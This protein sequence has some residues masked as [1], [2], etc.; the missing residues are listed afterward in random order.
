MVRSWIEK[1]CAELS[2]VPVPALSGG[3]FLLRFAPGMDIA[4]S[5]LD[6]GIG[7]KARL[8]PCPTSR[9]EECFTYLMRANLLGQGTGNS[10]LGLSEDE[11]DLTLSLGLPY[12]LD[13]PTFKE[14][15]EDFVN[16]LVYW[17]NAIADFENEKPIY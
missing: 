3:V 15:L 10:R 2:I 8:A 5:D 4:I 13:Y 1:L 12:E 14:T 17:Q 11:K 16:H 7:F 6:P 9:R